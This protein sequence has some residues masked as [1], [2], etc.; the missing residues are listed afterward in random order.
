MKN[1]IYILVFLFTF[2]SF[3]Q[4][5]NVLFDIKFGMTKSEIKKIF[6]ADKEKYTKIDLGGWLWRY[7][8]QNNGYDENGGLTQIKLNPVGG[9]LYGLPITDS[10]VLFKALLRVLIKQGY[11]NDD[12]NINSDNPLEFTIGE[13]YILSNK[14]KNRNVYIGLPPMGNNVYMNLVI[15]KYVDIL[16]EGTETSNSPF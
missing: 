3:S 8:Y 6:K 16:E 1:I 5:D 15:G 7:Y 4:D 11:T 12:I 2:S 14:E 9:G 10:R 13:V